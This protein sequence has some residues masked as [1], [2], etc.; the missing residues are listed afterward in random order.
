MIYKNQNNL[1]ALALILGFI[2]CG[3]VL[4]QGL[5]KN[6]SLLIKDSSIS[7]L[8]ETIKN[9]KNVIINTYLLGVSIYKEA[10]D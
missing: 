2:V 6:E 3:V 1:R 10:V 9:N 4:G 8:K 5:T 7:N